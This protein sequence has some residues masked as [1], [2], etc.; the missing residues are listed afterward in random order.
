MAEM[1]SVLFFW[2]YYI[3]YMRGHTNF[4][5]INIYNNTKRRHKDETYNFFR[6]NGEIRRENVGE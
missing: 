2:C 1:L 5:I 6:V 3:F 4:G